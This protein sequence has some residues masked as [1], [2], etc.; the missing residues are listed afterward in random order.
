MPSGHCDAWENKTE[1]PPCPYPPLGELSRDAAHTASGNYR[2]LG[3][4]F[5]HYSSGSPGES[6]QKAKVSTIT[7]PIHT[8]K[9]GNGLDMTMKHCSFL[10]CITCF[11]SSPTHQLPV[12]LALSYP[13]SRWGNGQLRGETLFKV[14]SQSPTNVWMQTGDCWCQWLLMPDSLHNPILASFIWSTMIEKTK[15]DI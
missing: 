13:F 7:S 12:R 1:L 8:K 11:L 15:S 14:T 5:P 9:G 6:W 10:L 3:S 4:P 2:W